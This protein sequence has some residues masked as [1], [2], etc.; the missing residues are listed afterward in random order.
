[1]GQYFTKGWED[2][3]LP[4]TQ[5]LVDPEDEW[6]RCGN[7]EQI[8]EVSLQKCPAHL[9]LH[10]SAVQRIKRA[11]QEEEWILDA[12]EAFHSKASIR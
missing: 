3:N 1:M 11:G 4:P 7:H 9:G 10:P 5:L 8:V 6:E 12:S 2:A